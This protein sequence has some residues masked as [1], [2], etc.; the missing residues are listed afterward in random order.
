MGESE[1]P[2]RVR[3][4]HRMVDRVAAILEAVARS[5][6]LSLTEIAR[7]LDAPVS[8]A[9]G[10]VNGLVATGY[11][12]ERGRVYQ[13]GVAPYFI[14]LLAG[15]PAVHRVGHDD[16]L[17][18]HA[19][20]GNTAVVA[21]AVGADVVYLDHCST[22]PRTAYLAERFIRRQLIRTSTG[23][24]L[25]ADWEQRDLWAYLETL[26]PEDSD[27]VERF[28][29]AMDKI[30]SGGVLVL[31]GAA[32]NPDLDGIAVPVRE[33]G[34][35]VAAVGVVGPRSALVP[36]QDEIADALRRHAAIWHARG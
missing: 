22:E 15:R 3:P 9:Q 13:L 1:R 29:G 23:W 21:V 14:N 5:D 24:L 2:T 4:R 18:L 36:H 11:L 32:E 28:L 19:E 26:G 12:D 34:R 25:L 31:P 33:R 6:G 20:T 30:R 17:A 8:S 10:L 27:R 16:L 7:R 35:V